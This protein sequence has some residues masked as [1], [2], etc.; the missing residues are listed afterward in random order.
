MR[1]STLCSGYLA[2]DLFASTQ[3]SKD[4]RRTFHLLY[5]FCA[6]IISNRLHF[7]TL[8]PGREPRYPGFK[9]YLKGKS[10]ST[11]LY[12]SASPTAAELLRR[13]LCNLVQLLAEW[14]FRRTEAAKREREMK[15]R[16]K[17]KT[18]PLRWSSREMDGGRRGWLGGVFGERAPHTLS[19]LWTGCRERKRNDFPL[20]RFITK[21]Y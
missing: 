19:P 12:D 1:T 2:A 15:G 13:T 11:S 10:R 6:T 16:G 8:S 14:S 7:L 17:A 18:P 20:R 3:D 4:Q 21:M 5:T 9:S